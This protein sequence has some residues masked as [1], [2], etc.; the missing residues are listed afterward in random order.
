MKKYV[1]T[2]LMVLSFGTFVSGA[3]ALFFDDIQELSPEST[4]SLVT[5][6]PGTAAHTI[7]GH[8]FIRIQDPLYNLDVM[9]NYGVY[10]PNQDNFYLKF[11]DGTAEYSGELQDSRGTIAAYTYY[12]VDLVQQD[13]RMTEAQKNKLL[14]LIQES[15]LPENKYYRY[16]FFFDNCSTRVR[17]LLN[18]AT[19]GAIIPDGADG[20][21]RTIRWWI[22]SKSLP[23]YPYYDYVYD[24]FL[25]R[26]V[27]QVA[28]YTDEM[29]LP[30]ML[31]QGVAN[32]G[33]VVDGVTYPLVIQT[34]SLN[35]I[36][37][38]AVDASLFQ[39]PAFWW[40]MIFTLTLVGVFYSIV[41]QKGR[42]ALL[43]FLIF[44]LALLGILGL[45]FLFAQFFSLHTVTHNNIQIWWMWP[46]HLLFALGVFIK[47]LH[48]IARC[49][50]LLWI[51]SIVAVAIYMI[52]VYPVM[53]AFFPMQLT[54]L[55]LAIWYL[56]GGESR[57]S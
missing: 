13:L 48:R 49:Y 30:D 8:T 24:L 29:F 40:W 54:G 21:G 28:S 10:N 45:I 39:T 34:F 36:E 56:L 51:V 53:G 35:D 33:L 46:T 4:V 3:G 42:K 9:A 18:E 50:L 12:D 32:G 1:L 5:A 31:F 52:I 17:D 57:R 47:R 41:A 44:Y 6:G 20:Q 37:R 19:D 27:D 22:D 23:G 14:G 15:L 16:D 38:R 55:I 7:F 2:I 43:S 26:E 11:L 25:G